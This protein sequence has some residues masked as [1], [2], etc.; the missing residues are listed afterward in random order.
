MHTSCTPLFC[1]EPAPLFYNPLYLCCYTEPAPLCP[2][3]PPTFVPPI[4]SC[5]SALSLAIVLFLPH[6]QKKTTHTR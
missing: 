6:L 3:T 2:A 1:T 5:P 4:L